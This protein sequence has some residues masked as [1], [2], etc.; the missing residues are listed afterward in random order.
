MAYIPPTTHVTLLATLRRERRLPAA[1]EV[2]VQ[3]RQRVEATDE[4]AHALVASH[5]RLVDVA[6][7]L[8]LPPDKAPAHMLKQEGEPVKSGEPI[9]RR[10]TALGLGSRTLKSPVDGY[11]LF[12]RHGKAVLAAISEAYELRAGIPGLIV[13]LEHEQSVAIE[14]TG[15]LLE[16]VWGNGVGKEAFAVMSVVG[17]APDA[18]LLSE[19]ID[20][21]ARS[22]ILAAGCLQD[23]AAFRRLAEM[24][25]RGLIVGTLN[26]A[27]IPA[28]SKLDLP[29]VVTD[30]FGARGLSAPAYTLLVSNSGREA[31]VNAQT[32]D[33]FRGARPEVIIP[34]PAPGADPPAPVDGDAL[35]VGKRVRICRG[36]EAGITGTVKALSD[37]P[38]RLPSGV[39]AHAAFVEAEDGGQS[40]TIPFAN[41]E[42]LE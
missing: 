12:V 18:P 34:L 39:R 27:L 32:W 10:K 8:S 37:Q 15:A 1:G 36:A 16:G 2:R 35:A 17:S 6:R 22:S 40:Y 7:G 33:R 28:V 3:M 38:V 30:G 20:V 31:W 29:V 21:N 13:N 9:A 42:I 14:T 11:F 24:N 23:D 4:V 5:H 19:Q 41:L 26:P 25:V